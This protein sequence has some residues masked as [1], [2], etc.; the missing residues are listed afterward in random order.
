MSD[1]FESLVKNEPVLVL[2]M[3]STDNE[4]L[5]SAEEM[6]NFNDYGFQSGIVFVTAQLI[7]AYSR[8]CSTNDAQHLYETS[9]VGFKQ[10]L[11]LSSLVC[12][13]ASTGQEWVK[14]QHGVGSDWGF[15][16]SNTAVWLNLWKNAADMNVIKWRW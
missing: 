3:F 2:C 10:F 8:W 15:T 9:W 1:H 16:K 14:N 6:K 5:I 4:Q 13:F 11:K 7:Q 12:G